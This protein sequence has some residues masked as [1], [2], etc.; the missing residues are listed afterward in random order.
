MLVWA[1]I[2]RNE[3]RFKPSECISF[4]SRFVYRSMAVAWLPSMWVN[5]S[6]A[7]SVSRKAGHLFIPFY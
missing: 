2:G 4:P 6:M 7:S 5:D 1:K 3:V